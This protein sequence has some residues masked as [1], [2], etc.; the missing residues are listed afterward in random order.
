MPL[1]SVGK[2]FVSLL[3]AILQDKGLVNLDEPIRAI[4]AHIQPP[5]PEQYNT[6]TL[7]QLLTMTAG[8]PDI[9]REQEIKYDDLF[10][11]L[12]EA[13]EFTSEPGSTYFYSNL[14]YSLAGYLLAIQALPPA[15]GQSIQFQNVIN[16]FLA[17][18]KQHIYVP[19]QMDSA[20][21]ENYHFLSLMDAEEC[22]G[23]DGSALLP[24]GLNVFLKLLFVNIFIPLGAVR[25]SMQH[26][27]HLM[28]MEMNLGV[29]HTGIRLVSS[30]NI[31]ERHSMA[32]SLGAEFGMGWFVDKLAGF[33]YMIGA[34]SSDANS[35]IWMDPATGVG[36]TYS[37]TLNDNAYGDF[38][39]IDMRRLFLDVVKQYKA[40]A[41]S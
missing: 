16:N 11:M 2:I 18:L 14:S 33:M 23:K 37:F 39:E 8:L 30:N 7:R 4:V 40:Y 26:L 27:A 29:A 6:L 12:R 10:D 15:P 28:I 3:A 34:M 1:G 13:V 24:A 31:Q 36:L 17:L 21:F 41:H 5:L 38:I 19:L 35:G 32:H 25:G 22:V 9:T 20:E